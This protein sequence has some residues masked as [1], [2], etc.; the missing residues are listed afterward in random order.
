MVKKS[1]LPARKAQPGKHCSK[2]APGSKFSPHPRQLIG[3]CLTDFS[4]YFWREFWALMERG[5]SEFYVWL[6]YGQS[7]LRDCW[8]FYVSMIRANKK[9]RRAA[10]GV[11][12]IRFPISFRSFWTCPWS[13]G[14][15]KGTG[16]FP[17]K[18]W[19]ALTG[20]RDS[21]GQKSAWDDLMYA[22]IVKLKVY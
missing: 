1:L 7:D 19:V 8:L 3:H 21:C 5:H 10:L 6:G 17:S 20:F 15:S 12:I 2:L 22:Q 14:R 13:K 4:D 11:L 16:G 18:S 9:Q